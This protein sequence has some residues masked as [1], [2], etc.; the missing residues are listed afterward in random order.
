MTPIE[1]YN[2]GKTVRTLIEQLSDLDREE[3]G[4]IISELHAVIA[5]CGRLPYKNKLP[6]EQSKAIIGDL[7]A[8]AAVSRPPRGWHARNG[9]LSGFEIRMNEYSDWLDKH[10]ELVYEGVIDQRTNR[11]E[12]LEAMMK[13]DP[14]H[15]NTQLSNLNKRK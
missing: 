10:P 8:A 5:L 7:L 4:T 15:C 11:D 12:T 1:M 6:F 13:Q 14:V 9:F 2:I 3:A